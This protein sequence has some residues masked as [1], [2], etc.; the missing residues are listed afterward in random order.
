MRPHAE[1]RFQPASRKE[2]AEGVRPMDVP[3]KG[4]K[5]G[6]TSSGKTPIEPPKNSMTK[7]E[8]LNNCL[9][10]KGEISGPAPESATLFPH[11]SMILALSSPLTRRKGTRGI[12]DWS[13]QAAGRLMTRKMKPR[14]RNVHGIPYAS[15]RAEVM[16]AK[17]APPTPAP[18]YVNPVLDD[19]RSASNEHHWDS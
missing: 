2:A 10:T 19:G 11:R 15:T 13:S 9:Y 6:G 8:S 7:R 1:A 17:T 5:K 4:M 18:A 14:A 3:N 16:G 12:L